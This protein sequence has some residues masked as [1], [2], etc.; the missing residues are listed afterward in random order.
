L[1][2]C[3]IY[4]TQQKSTL[5][6]FTVALLLLVSCGKHILE[7]PN[8]ELMAHVTFCNDS[9]YLI[10]IHKDHF[11]GTILAEKLIPAECFS[12][13][14][15]PSN[16]NGAGTVFSVEYWHVIEND[17]WVGGVDPYRQITE[18]IEA[19]V[20]STI[21]IPQPKS[22]NLKESF[23]KIVNV[24]D[25]DL[26]LN[27]LNSTFYQ[28]NKTLSVSSSKSGLYSIN[29]LKNTVCFDDG[30]VKNLTVKQGKS[31]LLPEF[32]MTNGYIYNFKFD[33]YEVIQK[34]P[35]SIM[36]Q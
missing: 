28:V 22:L 36:Q 13:E 33:G 8:S 7:A 31:F 1:E 14:V 21:S 10:T 19:G 24:S 32:T 26:E 27:C 20:S 3:N 11:D 12:T 9:S 35:E 29:N 15:S 17:I 30:E 23:I 34:E 6:Y 4:F 25:M 5:L 2:I 16:N 18:N